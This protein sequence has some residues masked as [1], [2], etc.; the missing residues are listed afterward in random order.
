MSIVLFVLRASLLFRNSG[1]S[2][3][4]QGIFTLPGGAIPFFARAFATRYLS[5]HHDIFEIPEF[6][7]A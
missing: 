2:Y 5:L 1:Q 6:L 3:Q 4:E 7:G